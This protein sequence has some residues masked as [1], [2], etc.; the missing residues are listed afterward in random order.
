LTAK[1][2]PN[3]I[4]LTP[5]GDEIQ[6]WDSVGT[7]GEPQQRRYQVNGER[8]TSVST[9][10]GVLDKPGIP[11]WAVRLTREGK[12]WLAERDAAAERGTQT[13]E[14]VAR[15]I[16][17]ERASLADLPDDVR[18]WGQAAYRWLADTEPVREMVETM[19]CWPK[20]R[21]AGRIDLVAQIDGVRTLVDFK[22]REDWKLTKTGAKEPP[23][24]S[25]LLQ[26]DLYQ[27]ALAASGH[28]VAERGLIVR[29]GP[30]GSYDETFAKLD[31]ERGRR[32][33][34]AY[35]ARGE[36]REQLKA[37]A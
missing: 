23:Y 15:L 13:H 29:L 35:R 14:L 30:D 31:P 10:V 5:A 34:D 25:N 37:A 16:Q 26:L 28:E 17:G 4:E 19:V 2:P 33:L 8:Y 3:H 36:A 1:R 32:I 7:D 12:D 27:G 6:F 20:V 9:A 24:E 11:H 21:L 18:A 22:T